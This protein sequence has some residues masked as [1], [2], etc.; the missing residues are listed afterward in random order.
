MRRY[1]QLKVSTPNAVVIWPIPARSIPCIEFTFGDPYLVRHVHEPLVEIT[2]PAVLIGA[3]TYQRVQLESKG[4]VESFAI[5]FQPMGLQRLFSLPGAVLVNE[6]YEADAVLGSCFT[7]LRTELGEAESFSQRVQIADRFF[8]RF[9]P[10]WHAHRG[11]EALVGVMVA[12]QGCVRV[13]A[14]ADGMG[15]SLRQF[16]RRF[17]NH[18]GIGPKVYARILRFEAAIHKKSISSLNWTSIAHELGYC[19]QAHMIHD[20]QSLSSESPSRLI[21][22]FET[23]SAICADFRVRLDTPL[24]G[25]VVRT[26]ANGELEVFS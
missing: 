23:L 19:D 5:F 15:L 11:F 22:Y 14:L 3:K 21:P 26:T 7:D 12:Q 16:E 9:I 1:A 8:G 25:G 4:H 17:T 18:V 24:R 6:H 20:F 2:R 10:R 13:Q